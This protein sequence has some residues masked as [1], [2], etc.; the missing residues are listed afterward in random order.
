[1][2]ASHAQLSSCFGAV[3]LS[4]ISGLTNTS[5]RKGVTSIC[6]IPK[7]STGTS[8]PRAFPAPWVRHGHKLS[9]AWPSTAT[10]T[11]CISLLQYSIYLPFLCVH[12][13]LFPIRPSDRNM[14][15]LQQVLALSIA[16]HLLLHVALDDGALFADPHTRN[17]CFPRKP[18]IGSLKYPTTLPHLRHQAPGPSFR[19]FPREMR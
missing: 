17:A 9:P 3:G 19:I 8:L 1:M 15:C 10:V 16:A 14:G 12:V 2:K 11:G 13:L 18:H 6:H 4:S 5:F 7:E